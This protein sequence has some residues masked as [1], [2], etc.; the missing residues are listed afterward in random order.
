MGGYIQYLIIAYNGK[1][2]EKECTC[3]AIPFAAHLKLTL[4]YK[5]NYTSILKNYLVYM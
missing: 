5:K 2:S 1:E 4:H 3:V